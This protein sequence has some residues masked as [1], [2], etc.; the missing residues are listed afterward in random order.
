MPTDA[1]TLRSAGFIARYL[2]GLGDP[3]DLDT[4]EIAVWMEVIGAILKV[5]RGRPSDIGPASHR[6]RVE[7]EMRRLYG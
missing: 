2:P 6:S 4:T 3:M 7:D 5:E 1:E